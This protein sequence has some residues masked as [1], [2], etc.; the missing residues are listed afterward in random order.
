MLLY[1]CVDLFQAAMKTIT[2]MGASSQPQR[3]S[4]FT[5]SNQQQA[6][7]ASPEKYK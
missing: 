2:S 5:I 3:D 6:T 1:C 4:F 7:T